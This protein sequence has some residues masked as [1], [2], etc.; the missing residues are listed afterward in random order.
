MAFFSHLRITH[1]MIIAIVV[2]TI[3]LYSL[4]YTA[5]PEEMSTIVHAGSAHH[6]I[7]SSSSVR[8]V[9]RSD[10]SNINS[11]IDRDSNNDDKLNEEAPSPSSGVYNEDAV[12]GQNM[13]EGN[14]DPLDIRIEMLRDESGTINK[15]TYS[16]AGMFLCTVTHYY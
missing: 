16:L 9:S 10:T 12:I 13:V 6:L 5:S 8:I 3:F 14:Y 7:S 2:L 1:F 4:I 11:N 15:N